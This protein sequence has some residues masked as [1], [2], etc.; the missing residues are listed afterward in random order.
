[1][2]FQYSKIYSTPVAHNGLE[3]YYDPTMIVIAA[4]D[5]TPAV[6]YAEYYKLTDSEIE[7]IISSAK[8]IQVRAI[9][10]QLL[11]ESD[12]TQIPDVPSDIKDAYTQYR[13]SLRSLP[14]DFALADDVVFPAKPPN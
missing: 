6:T 3:F 10:N 7:S 9:R 11:A 14:Q 1:M 13:L 8:W 2:K 5:E 4:T 12:W